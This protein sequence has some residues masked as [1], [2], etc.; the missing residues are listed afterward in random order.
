[1]F[2]NVFNFVKNLLFTCGS[3]VCEEIRGN[4]IRHKIMIEDIG[5]CSRGCSCGQKLCACRMG[6]LE[7]SSMMM[8]TYL[9]CVEV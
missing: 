7:K 2:S 1:M 5:Q 3:L 9:L 6:G 8:K 4:L